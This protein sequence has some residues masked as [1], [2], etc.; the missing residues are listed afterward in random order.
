MASSTENQ[1]KLANLTTRAAHQ[2]SL[3]NHA[4]ATELYSE[5]VALQDEIN[6]EMNPANAELLFRYGKSL[7]QVAVGKSDVLGGGAASKPSGA[8]NGAPSAARKSAGSHPPASGRLIQITNDDVES[9]SEEEE[10]QEEEEEE[11]EDDDF[12]IA[13]EVLDLARVLFERRLGELNETSDVDA[14]QGSTAKG[15]SNGTGMK[16]DTTKDEGSTN[17]ARDADGKDSSTSKSQGQTIKEHLSEIHDIQA[18][19]SLENERFHDAV[20]DAT[21]ALALK[22]N[23]YPQ[24]SRLVAEAH[25]KLALA[26]EFASLIPSE[27]EGK[28]TTTQDHHNSGDANAKPAEGGK[29]A[30]TENGS[31]VT[32]PEKKVLRSK[33]AE[34][35]SLAIRSSEMHLSS[36]LA[37]K[38]VASKEVTEIKEIIA[39]MKLRLAELRRPVDAPKVEEEEV[40]DLLG[41]LL[42]GKGLEDVVASAKDVSGLVKRKEAVASTGGKRKAEEDGE[43][44]GQGKKKRAG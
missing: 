2:S 29:T 3:K 15:E 39:E 5:A 1:S 4:A 26:L 34:Q 37:Q 22:K 20:N 24:S 30:N 25:F 16:Q 17:A 11:E 40:K 35:I 32:L 21:K 43:G 44:E 8:A 23:L 9:A 7:F 28:E 31:G 14:K 33:A 27:Q 41:E 19:I 12:A 42:K 36:L 6:G 10:G 13:W 38:G 18:E